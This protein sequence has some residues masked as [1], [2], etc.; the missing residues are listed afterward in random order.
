MSLLAR[1]AIRESLALRSPNVAVSVPVEW[2][3][4][5][6]LNPLP[7]NTFGSALVLPNLTVSVVSL[8][9]ANLRVTSAD[10]SCIDDEPLDSKA[11]AVSQHLFASW[12]SVSGAQTLLL[13]SSAFLSVVPVVV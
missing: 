8:S 9:W 7:G 13:V 1:S 3:R 4:L 5:R 12:S 10:Y 11:S 2:S 6:I